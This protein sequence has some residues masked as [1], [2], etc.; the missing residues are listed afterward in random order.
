M[1]P[2]LFEIELFG[3][4][5]PVGGYGLM[6]SLGVLATGF[7]AARAAHRHGEDW[8]AV[9]ATIGYA[10]V[11]AFLGAG[12]LFYAVE[13][14][15]SGFDVAR[16]IERGPGVVFYGA[17][18]G[19]VLGT[20]YAAKL[21]RVPW[22]KMVD[23]SVPGIAIGHALGRVGCF[24]GGCCYGAEWHGPW[25]ALATHPMAPM[26]NPPVPRHPVQVYE[27]VGLA[28]LALAFAATPLDVR[29]FGPPGSGRR[30]FAYCVA[31]GVLRFAIEGLRGDAVRGVFFGGWL[32]TSQIVSVGLV[33]LGLAGFVR[34][35]RSNR[36]GEA[37]AQA[38]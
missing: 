29:I 30:L 34:S 13:F 28:V 24:L 31:Y 2:I 1:H 38:S 15:R 11:P 9:V 4:S 27:A 20:W 37:R 33:A 25:A 32:S 23:L 5:R 16:V 36:L 35:L 8:G 19:A 26:A 12:A 3:A 18:P 21:L 17:V 10:M 22:W 14:V 7:L 6:V